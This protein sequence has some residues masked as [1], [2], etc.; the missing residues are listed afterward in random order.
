MTEDELVERLRAL[1]LA[2]GLA[3]KELERAMTEFD[4]VQSAFLEAQQEWVERQL[5]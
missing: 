5:R 4:R 3:M 2:T 1:A